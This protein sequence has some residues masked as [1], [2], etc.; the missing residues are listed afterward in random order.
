M[1]PRSKL[2]LFVFTTVLCIV[3][4]FFLPR[5]PQPPAYADFADKRA[6]L[7]IPNFGDVASNLF[8]LLAGFYGIAVTLRRRNQFHD[9][10]EIVAWLI[11][12]AGVTLTAFGSA[13]FHL[14]PNNERLVWDRL[15]MTIGFMALFAA[16]LAERVS[17]SLGFR[18]LPFLLAVGAGSVIYWI[19]T[20]HQGR[21]DLRAYLLV[22][23]Y[24]LLAIL[25]LLWLFP[26]RYT[27][28]Y[29]YLVGL[30]F[31]AAA[32]ALEVA[33]KPVFALTRHT[34][35]GHTLKHIAAAVGGYWLARMI[36]L[37]EPVANRSQHSAE[38]ASR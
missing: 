28:G 34:V 37:R 23:F 22:Q 26:A 9:S 2:A 20:E 3:A 6:L 21:G 32:K 18:L 19:W 36:A 4:V 27:R 25:L 30:G 17:V 24:P 16:L 13:Y 11:L 15:P 14:L 5:I 29:D 8:F 31:Y 33:D 35:S 12:F 38:A 1:T 10:R 7:G